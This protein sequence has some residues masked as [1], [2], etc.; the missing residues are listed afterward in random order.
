MTKRT[1]L[2]VTR[3]LMVLAAALALSG[4]GVIFGGS[5]KT[6]TVTSTPSEARLTTEPLTGSFT[7]PATLE[8]ERKKSYTL[9]VWK[10]GY[11]EAQFPIQRKVRAGP[12]IMDILFGLVPV[13][14]D[15]VT[16]G[17]WDL[18]P[19]MPSVTLERLEDGV[20]PE[21]IEVM[22]SLDAAG[23]PLQIDATEAVQIQVIEN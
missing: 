12:L 8:L 15:A 5:T 3:P 14:V 23:G 21:T 10:E 11:R 22:F 18:Q 13:V 1:G 9:V 2:A 19:E 7:T 4:C 16:G 17:L 20:G 6:L